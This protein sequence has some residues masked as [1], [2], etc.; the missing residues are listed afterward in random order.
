MPSAGSFSIFLRHELICLSARSHSFMGLL[1]LNGFERG[2]VGGHIHAEE[3]APFEQ[4]RD[5]RV[6]LGLVEGLARFDQVGERGL[7]RP[8]LALGVVGLRDHGAVELLGL[9]Q[10]GERALQVAAAKTLL[11]LGLPCGDPRRELVELA[12]RDQR[13]ERVVEEADEAGLVRLGRR[14]ARVTLPNHLLV[15]VEQ[16]DAREVPAVGVEE[17]VRVADAR[18]VPEVDGERA[19]DRVLLE[20]GLDGFLVVRRADGDDLEPDVAVLV[21]E[22]VHPLVDADDPVLVDAPEDEDLRHVAELVPALALALDPAIDLRP[23]R[24]HAEVAAAD[25]R[26]ALGLQLLVHDVALE[27]RRGV[28]RVPREEA[29]LLEARGPRSGDEPEGAV[30]DVLARELLRG[31]QLAVDPG[32]HQV[33]DDVDAQGVPRAG[34]G[35]LGLF[36]HGDRAVSPGLRRRAVE[37]GQVDEAGDGELAALL[38]LP[39]PGR[40]SGRE[41]SPRPCGRT[42]AHRSSPRRGSPRCRPAG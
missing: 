2:L 14:D 36:V 1:A 32:V 10:Q 35:L 13:I 8:E 37:R 6:A 40:G 22:V 38:G 20:V 5:G 34:L 4:H 9:A 30:Q 16:Q 33:A 21:R 7:E 27:L 25:G 41:S 12:R 31:D 3:P 29:H 23:R 24:D 19:G 18:L 39:C 42:P 11:A 15:D 17:L 26:A 28:A